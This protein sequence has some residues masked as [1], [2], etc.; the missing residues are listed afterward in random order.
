MTLCAREQGR[1]CPEGRCQ[2]NGDAGRAGERGRS[3]A[4]GGQAAGD[5]RISHDCAVD[6]DL[7]QRGR[8]AVTV[9]LDSIDA[10]ILG[11]CRE[12]PVWMR[13]LQAV[14]PRWQALVNA[15]MLTKIK[16][17]TGTAHNMVAITAKGVDAIEAHWARQN[18]ARR[19]SMRQVAA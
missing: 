12:R 14:R 18:K 5:E 10:V 11:K 7:C 15:G 3:T 19:D 8:S 4:H 6:A 17:P 13:S 16:P 9:K 2:G 1:D